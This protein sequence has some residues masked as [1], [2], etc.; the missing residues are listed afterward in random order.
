MMWKEF[1]PD[2][3]LKYSFMDTVMQILPMYMLRAVGGSLYLTGVLVM[4][5]N[6]VKTVAS[7][8]LN[9]NEAAQHPALN[10]SAPDGKYAWHRVLERKPALFTLL[11]AVAILI[12][13]II[14]L[15]P[16][17]LIKSNIDPIA[18]VKPYT[19]LE[20]HG[21]DIYIREGC[22][23]CHTQWVRPLTDEVIRY[24][25]ILDKGIPSQAGEYVYDHTFLWGSKRTGPDLHRVGKKY[26]DSWH[27]RHMLAP[28]DVTTNSIMPSYSW[29]FEQQTDY[30]ITETK[31]RALSQLGVPYDEKA[32]A[33]AAKD[34]EKQAAEI[35]ANLKTQLPDMD[36][37]PADREIM[38]LIAYLQ[39]LGTDIKAT[40]KTYVPTTTVSQ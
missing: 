40:E 17:F 18:A 7:G 39:R 3:T 12:G 6:L 31:I 13:G 14:E 26:P 19:P 5:Y 30:G 38:A 10:D 9:A 32:V 22:N 37:V 36:L 27:Y 34:A 24:Q 4:I 2:G 25:G 20:V 1:N 8:R 35:H 21:R 16:T 11:A 23:A 15:V 28:A 33:T 29:L